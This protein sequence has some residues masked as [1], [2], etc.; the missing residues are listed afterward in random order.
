ME[1]TTN[2]SNSPRDLGNTDTKSTK[3][4]NAYKEWVA[5]LHIGDNKKFKTIEEWNATINK[6]RIKL[7]RFALEM[8][9]SGATPHIQIAMIMKEKQRL[10]AMKK[11]LNDDTVHLER[12]RGTWE[13]QE[14]CGKEG[15][16]LITNDRR[17][18]KITYE[19]RS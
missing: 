8:G 14:Y 17:T 19:L 12:M 15:L 16:T 18:K 2:S 9:K 3:Q 5:T 6:D 7:Y 10:T 1:D 11:L 13:Q 4:G